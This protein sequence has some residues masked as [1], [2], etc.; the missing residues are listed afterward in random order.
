MKQK[1]EL[2]LSEPGAYKDLLRRL[3]YEDELVQTLIM[4]SGSAADAQTEETWLTR[5]CLDVPYLDEQITDER[6]LLLIECLPLTAGEIRSYSITVTACCH[7]NL[8]NLSA[9]DRADLNTRFGLTGNRVD[10]MVMAVNQALSKESAS[11]SF[12]IGK[13]RPAA[14]KPVVSFIPNTQ[15]YGKTLTFEVF[16]MRRR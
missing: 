10:M 7:R 3:L 16:E 15:F 13:L 6:S 11:R 1:N 8:I 12:G 5:H 4:P 2:P 9:A 14:E